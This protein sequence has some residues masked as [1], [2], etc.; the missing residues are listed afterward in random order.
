[1]VKEKNGKVLT[2]ECRASGEG[3]ITA[4]ML[5]ADPIAKAKA[6]EE[7]FN[8]VWKEEEVTCPYLATGE[9]SIFYQSQE[10]SS[11]SSATVTETS[12]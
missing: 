8:T 3:R 10:R 1:M 6:L 2:K 12:F 9:A 11:Y 5:K 4:D 7:P